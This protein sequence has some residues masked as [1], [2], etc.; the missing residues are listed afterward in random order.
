MIR[1]AIWF[2]APHDYHGGINYFKNLL[3]AVSKVKNSN[4]KFYIFFSSD[5]PEEI[6]KIFRP[7]GK[8]IIT[9]VLTRYSLMWLIHQLLMR[10]FNSA[11]MINI[12]FKLYSIDIVSHS[13]I[14]I[15]KNRN[16][17]I[18]TWIPDFQ[19][20]HLPEF[21]PNLDEQDET[22]NLKEIISNSQ[23][24]IL[25]SNHA[26]KDFSSICNPKDLQKGTV[27]NFVSQPSHNDIE[28][29]AID[30]FGIDKKFF[31][32]PN[33]FWKHKN[34][35]VVFK[36]IKRLKDKGLNLS[37]V[38]SGVTHDHRLKENTY[39]NEIF[40]YIEENSLG[41]NINILGKIEYKY[42]LSLMK[43]SIAVINPS[44]FEGWSSTVE[45]AKSL[46]KKII[47]SDIEVH[48]EQNPKNSVYFD[49]KNEEILSKILENEFLNKEPNNQT[50]TFEETEADLEKRTNKFGVNYLNLIRKVYDEC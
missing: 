14:K 7:Y 41:D 8:I 30:K 13:W 32:L 2:D 44:F 3:Y 27:L 46:G 45:E 36:A 12:V 40:Q 16:Y 25:S 4:V 6:L 34:H 9:K 20:L 50:S 37:L 19:Y 29:N 31:F 43:K 47:L 18:I 49:P 17:K 21:F 15:K 38:C 35:L 48:K 39:L 23:C 22:K 5:M 24:V 1:I 26:Y 42:V 28:T 10:I 33:Q 11:L